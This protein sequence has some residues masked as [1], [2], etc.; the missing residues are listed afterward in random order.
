MANVWSSPECLANIKIIPDNM[1]QKMDTYSYGMILW[2]LMH[3]TI[4]F[5]SDVA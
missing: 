2:E 3:Q 1:N 4:P 5:D